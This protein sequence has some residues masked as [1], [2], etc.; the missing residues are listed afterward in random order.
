MGNLS[1]NTGALFEVLI[2]VFST[3]LQLKRTCLMA[4]SS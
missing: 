1:K 2:V 4:E 3:S